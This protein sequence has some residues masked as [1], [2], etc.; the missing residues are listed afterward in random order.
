MSID[1]C[2][3]GAQK[4]GTTTI[5]RVLEAQPGV[6]LAPVKEVHFFDRHFDRG[7]T[8]YERQFAKA[9]SGAIVG[10]ATPMYLF[11]PEVAARM[12][13]V[14]PDARLV[15][16]LRN[17]VDRAYSHYWHTRSRGDEP[18]ELRE[19]IAAEPERLRS[20][21]VGVRGRYSYV[22]KGRYAA[23]LQRFVDHFPREQLLVL[24]FDDLVR[25]PETLLA[26][27]CAHIGAGP[28]QLD[29]VATR[30]VGRHKRAPR[31]VRRVAGLMPTLSLRRRVRGLGSRA[32]GY[33]PLDADDR[34]LLNELLAP[35]VRALEAWLGRD[36]PW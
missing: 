1:F 26:Q 13:S 22:G 19:A 20:D 6:F 31:I 4:S 2:I 30:Q 7:L 16:I 17:P 8:W 35:E 5:A 9:P 24:L 25:E 18:L 12:A 3:I 27:V 11:E 15:A 32:T 29:G 23:Q 33:P 34:A 21:D 36:L 28:L 14:M 10:E